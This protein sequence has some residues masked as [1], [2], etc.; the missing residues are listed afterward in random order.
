MIDYPT[1]FEPKF[2]LECELHL[3][4]AR[5]ESLWN[6]RLRNSINVRTRRYL[7]DPFLRPI[8]ELKCNEATDFQSALL[9]KQVGMVEIDTFVTRQ[10]EFHNQVMLVVRLTHKALSYL[11]EFS[12]QNHEDENSPAPFDAFDA[13]VSG[14]CSY[15]C[16]DRGNGIVV[17]RDLAEVALDLHDVDVLSRT[18]NLT[19]LNRQFDFS[20]QRFATETERLEVEDHWS[21][22]YNLHKNGA[23]VVDLQEFAST[24]SKPGRVDAKAFA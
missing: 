24:N 15:L 1:G 5:E 10:L 2:L 8:C 12:H 7:S 21:C 4:T 16:I 6:D 19:S 17:T 13:L 18:M 22:S 23:A 9:L 3:S 20:L 11:E 14:V